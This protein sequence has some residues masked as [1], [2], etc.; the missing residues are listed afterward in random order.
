MPALKLNAEDLWEVTETTAF[1]TNKA[2]S[3]A[4]FLEVMRSALVQV[5]VDFTQAQ[6]GTYNKLRRFLPTMA[7]VME[8]PDLDLQSVATGQNC[9]L[10]RQR[11]FLQETK[12]PCRWGPLCRFPRPQILQVKQRCVDRL[13]ALYQ[14][15][16]QELAMTAEGFLC[17]DAWQ[18]AEVAALH[19]ALPE[20]RRPWQ[21]RN[22]SETS[23][24]LLAPWMEWRPGRPLHQPS[25]QWRTPHR[26]VWTRRQTTPVQP[27]MNP[28]MARIYVGCWLTTQRP[29]SLVGCARAR[30]C[31]SSVKKLKAEPCRG[32]ETSHTSKTC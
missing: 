12:A 5:G 24:S 10:G 16:R 18:W 1:I 6:S 13:F 23:R 14:K 11:P 2:M 19:Q 9:H 30:S 17:R 21:R 29:M 15:K 7:N 3:R 27:R 28:Q 26:P 32:A 20:D 8:L 31:T 4:R 25:Y 22:P